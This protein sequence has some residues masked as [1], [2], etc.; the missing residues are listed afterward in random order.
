MKHLKHIRPLGT[1][2]PSSLTVAVSALF[3]MG[4]VAA[5]DAVTDSRPSEVRQATKT[6]AL[7]SLAV[8]YQRQFDEQEAAVQQYLNANPGV[9][10]E[11]E[12]NGVR[13]R[14][15][16]IG[17][18]GQPVYQVNRYASA[19]NVASA[20]LIKADALH[21][22]G[23]LGLNITGT[24]MT[25]G[26]WEPGL[27]RTT[28]ELLQGKVTIESG[29]TASPNDNHASHVTG[30]IVGNPMTTGDGVS[31]RGVA[32]G[33]VSRNWDSANDA[34]EMAAAAGNLFVSNHSYGLANDTTTPVWQ[35]GAYDAEAAA[36]DRITKLAPY[37]LPFVAGGN[38][39]KSNG[40]MSKNGY[41]LMTGSSASK[42]VMTVGALNG[43]KAMSDYSN[44]GPT[45]DGRIKPE[46]VARGTAINSAQG[47]SDTA[48]SGSVE[49]SSGT[50]YATPASAGSALLLQQYFNSVNS[51]YMLASTLKTLMMG[52]AEDLGQPGPDNKFGY[53]LLNVEAAGRA[54]Q[55]NSVVTAATGSN[56]QVQ[57]SNSRGAL[58]YEWADNPPNDGQGELTLD[59]FAKGSQ[60]LVVNVGWTDDE[61]TEQTISHGIDPTDTR[62]VYDFDVLVTDT[63]TSTSYRPWVTPSLANRTDDAT[64]ATNWFQANGGPLRQVIVSAPTAGNQYKITVRKSASSPVTAR[65]LSVVATG[66][67]ES[68]GGTSGSNN[69]TKANCLFD[70]TERSFPDFLKPANPPS[71]TLG[72]F[73]YRVYSGPAAIATNGADNNFYYLG[74]LTG[75]Q[76]TKLGT[77]AEWLTRSGCQ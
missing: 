61:G 27:P 23:S 13:H 10:R 30:T 45:D 46:I 42:N 50:S 58:V 36:W 19:K 15:I 52:T 18:D 29:Q 64:K 62:T 11:V 48:Y 66:L 57:T 3:L 65:T 12:K 4:P 67:V 70:W 8:E 43:D 74:P 60:A 35:F 54:I 71:A 20:Q 26:V 72:D 1:Y 38:E 6:D 33:A 68:A 5:A 76:L 39:Q 63:A 34:A 24:G 51:R 37:Y 53:G 14:I 77:V 75:N 55:K 9:Q 7:S 47:T 22:G 49:S 17:Q 16:R 25:V 28:H 41:D 44:W 21:P 31:A 40:N 56:R 59:V 73:Y 2:V 32:Y 69:Q